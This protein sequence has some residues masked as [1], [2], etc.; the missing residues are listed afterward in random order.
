MKCVNPRK[1]LNRAA[2]GLDDYYIQVSCGKCYACLANRR[3][4]WLFRLMHENLNSVITLFV[5]LTYDQL[6]MLRDGTLTQGV[7]VKKHLQDFLK[8]LRNYEQFTYYCIGEYGTN[9]HRPH[10]HCA[11]FL[12]LLQL[13]T[14]LTVLHILSMTNGLMVLLVSLVPLIVG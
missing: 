8:R 7:L 9:T 3:R 5:T 11:L 14:L 1:L 4:S 6:S 13:L 10:Y 2:T 12:S